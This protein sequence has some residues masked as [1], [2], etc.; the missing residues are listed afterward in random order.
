MLK[1]VYASAAAREFKPAEL[2]ELLTLARQRNAAINV[3]GLLLYHRQSFFQIL[4]G[5]AN[6]VMAVYARIERDQ[7]HHRVLLLSRS[8]TDTRNFGAWRMGFV[9]ADRN[10]EKL[11]GFLK[12][13]KAKSTFLDLQG[14]SKAV[15]QLIDGFLDGRWRRSIN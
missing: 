8:E 14:D 5:E 9:D 10:V 2:H 7:R 6:D 3:T 12:F 4:E 11:P 1:L 13:L 15:A